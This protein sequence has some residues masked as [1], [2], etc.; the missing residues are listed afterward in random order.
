MKYIK[1]LETPQFFID[2]TKDL[3]NWK[4]YSLT[5]AISLKK[6]KLKKYILE[7]EQ[8]GLCCYCELD[9][10]SNN[11]LSHIEH[12]KPKSLDIFNLTFEYSNLLVSC[13]GNHFNEIGDN[14]ITNCGQFKKDNFDE[15]LFLNPTIVKN[16]SEYFVFN[17][18]G[19]ISTSVI[20]KIKA[21]FTINILNLNGKNN[22]LA[23]ARKKTKDA[24]VKKFYNSKL[25]ISVIKQKLIDYLKNDRN[26]FI[27]FLR[28]I[29]KDIK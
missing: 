2:D 21:D 7:N 5:K 17:S 22:I 4:D 6:I 10:I 11:K 24:L 20:D 28:Y 8:N 27:T 16:V 3:T 13:E 19:I 25:P 9:L 29:Y 15:E 18:D 23:E 26:E 14:T 12:I 1:K